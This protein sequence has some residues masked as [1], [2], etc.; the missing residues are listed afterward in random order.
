MTATTTNPQE[1][2]QCLKEA[3]KLQ[4]QYFSPELDNL[5][6]ETIG[7]I[8]FKVLVEHDLLEEGELQVP[9]RSANAWKKKVKAF[10]VK[11]R[12]KVEV[13]SERSM[14]SRF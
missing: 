8:L 1:F 13:E 7:S 14:Y 12:D 11:W 4:N 2:K 10:M 6:D 5:A 3:Y 9:T